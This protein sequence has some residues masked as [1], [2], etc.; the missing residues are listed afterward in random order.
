V[1][2]NRNRGWSTGRQK[3]RRGP[4]PGVELEQFTSA[5]LRTWQRQ[6][7]NL[8]KYHVQLYYH[9]EGLRSLH[10]SEICE[11]LWKS[12]PA[13]F[14]LDKWV[15]IIDYQY[16]LQPLSAAGSL[17]HGG[18]FNIGN[19]LDPSKFPVLRRSTSQKTTR[20]H[21]MNDSDWRLHCTQRLKDMSSHCGTPIR[22][23][24]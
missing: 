18:R 6:S 3:G 7:E 15:R 24:Q 16:S 8:E 12:K 17:A 10:N 23:R 19:D 20:Q 9:L 1:P 4:A 11:A 14:E 21:S 13:E 22:L 5:D 2:R